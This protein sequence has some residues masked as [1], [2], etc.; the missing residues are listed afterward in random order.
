MQGKQLRNEIQSKL[1]S[2]RVQKRLLPVFFW[3]VD[4]M[5]AFRVEPYV[6]C[7]SVER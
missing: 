3:K 6:R 1:E 4:A 7:S 5:R 2:L